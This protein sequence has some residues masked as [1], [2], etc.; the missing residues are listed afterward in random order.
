M[1]HNSGT[2]QG[3]QETKLIQL[4]QKDI[5]EIREKLQKEQKGICPIC[6][7][8]I[9]RPV[10]DHDHTK[11]VKGTGLC[12]QVI[13]SSCNVFLAKIENNA[14]RYSVSKQELPF[15]LLNISEY[16]LKPHT[17]YIHPSEKKPQPQIKKT[18]FNRLNKV[19]QGKFPRKKKL[20]FP[21]RGRLTKKLQGLFKDFHI[22]IEYRKGK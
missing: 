16:L 18:C 5:K 13:C 21:K 10:L 7:K 15:V 14:V 22:K 20:T 9:K 8:K 4:K 11:R 17:K 2:V 6:K 19:Y 3:I 1:G 12:R